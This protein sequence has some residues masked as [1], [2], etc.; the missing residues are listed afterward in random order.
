M[1]SRMPTLLA[2]GEGR[3]G[4]GSNRQ[5]HP[6]RSAGVVGTARWKGDAGNRGRPDPGDGRTVSGILGVSVRLGVGEGHRTVEADVMPAEER[7]LTSWR[8]FDEDE[9]R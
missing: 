1:K 8:A 4:W 5:K 3:A 9:D 7:T 2:Y 6:F